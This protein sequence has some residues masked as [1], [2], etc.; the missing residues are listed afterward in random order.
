MLWLD[1]LLSHT[2][3]VKANNKKLQQYSEHISYLEELVDDY[4]KECIELNRLYIQNKPTDEDIDYVKIA[5]RKSRLCNEFFS[6]LKEEQ[7][8]SEDLKRQLKNLETKYTND[9]NELIM[10]FA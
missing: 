9:T 7:Q 3:F 10:E 8:K 2:G 5:K 1:K 6:Q 4:R